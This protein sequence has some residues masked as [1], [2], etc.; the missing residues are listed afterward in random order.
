MKSYSSSVY[1][2]LEKCSGR[3]M[4][5]RVCPTEAIRVRGG[6]A[7]LIAERCIDCGECIKI[8]P[9]RA[10]IPA[11][12]SFSDLSHFKYTV[13][14]PSP[15]LY[16]QFGRDDTPELIQAA[17]MKLGFSEVADVTGACEAVSL[18]IREHLEHY[19]GRKPLISSFCPTIV[20]LI[21]VKYPDLAELVVPFE[22]PK[23]IVAREAKAQRSKELG[24]KQEEIGVIYL[25]PC[26]SKMIDIKFHPRKE[27]SFIDGAISIAE[28]YS[29]IVV[30]MAE[31]KN[32]TPDTSMNNISGIGLEWTMLGGQ[33][34][35]LQM[36]NSLAVDGLKN[37]IRA[38]E[39]IENGRLRDIDYLECHSCPE[40]CIGGSLT[41]ENPYV[42]R[43]N[44]I[45]LKKRYGDE[46]KRSS[47]EIRKLY[48]EK[49]FSTERRL[50]VGAHQR[51]DENIAKAIEKMRK[52]DAIYR[53]LP[54]INCGCCGA[55]NCSAFAEDV[56]QGSAEVTDCIFIYQERVKAT[57]QE[58]LRLLKKK[59]GYIKE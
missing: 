4:C 21:Q 34:A 27:K 44:L 13:A 9:N 42:S 32:A 59:P 40:G 22:S 46:P 17:L 30:L 29:S 26:P 11:T 10:I 24:L 41:V 56:V 25:T 16:G 23:E 5:M 8:C 20:R 47:E 2:N 53:N 31:M 52:K 50:P 14:I 3:M 45:R 35:S 49:Y 36:E 19:T 7:E 51:L 39:D 48:R 57:G 38:F 37:V 15:V 18:A 54:Q 6:K 58:M 33:T 43:S 1:V 12:D 28:I 55:P